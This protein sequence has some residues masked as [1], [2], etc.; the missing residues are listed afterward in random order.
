MVSSACSKSRPNRP[1]KSDTPIS[2]R[3]SVINLDCLPRL[4]H[5]N[6]ITDLPKPRRDTSRHR[7]RRPQRF[8]GTD[9]IVINREQR[10][11]PLALRC[12]DVPADVEKG[13]AALLALSR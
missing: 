4:K 2:Y 1:G 8:M 6:N 12:A 11:T 7:R 3:L 13:G 9:E 10:D 5:V